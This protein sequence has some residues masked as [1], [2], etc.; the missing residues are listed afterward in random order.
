MNSSQAHVS[1]NVLTGDKAFE[2]TVVRRDDRQGTDVHVSEN[3]QAL[4]ER[5]SR[6]HYVG[7]YYHV[8]A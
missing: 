4:G 2:T 7:M 6:L 8:R 1:E 5:V 3:L